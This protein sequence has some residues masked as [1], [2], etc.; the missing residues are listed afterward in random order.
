MARFVVSGTDLTV[1]L[2]LL[3]RFLAWRWSVRAPLS[4]VTSVA[5]LGSSGPERV[6]SMVSM[7]FAATSAPM[8]F[9]AAVGPRARTPDGR[10]AFVVTYLARAAVL[11]RL[12]GGSPWSLLLVSGRHPS[13]VALAITDAVGAVGSGHGDARGAP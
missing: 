13:A 10:P 3:E 12:D 9:V 6:Q 5:V 8:G 2:S 4:A 11:V 7:G 1:R